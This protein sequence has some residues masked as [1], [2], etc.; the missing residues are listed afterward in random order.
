MRRQ[1]F[2]NECSTGNIKIFVDELGA[3]CHAADMSQQ[4]VLEEIEV[5]KGI[6]V[7]FFPMRPATG[8]SL[9]KKVAMEI[10][11]KQ[12]EHK[13]IYQ[14][15]LNGDRAILA[16]VDRRVVLCNRHFG[17]Y[18]FQVKNAPAFLTLADGTLFDGE[19][20]NG[21]FYPFDCLAL[22]GRSH[23]ANT[24]EE[25]SIMAMQMCRLLKVEW[26]YPKPTKK[27]L[28]N[29]RKNLPKYEGVVRKRA[30]QGYFL[31]HNSTETSLGWLKYRW[32]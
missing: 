10:L 4:Q 19:V 28:L 31:L 26:M 27:W 9:G 20:W 8:P 14:P 18:S 3:V 12:E 1:I 21:N 25:R 23:R 15:K 11:E 16:V 24:A 29:L 22:E 7:P 17:W 2:V 13:Y 30:D 6:I 5:M 32:A